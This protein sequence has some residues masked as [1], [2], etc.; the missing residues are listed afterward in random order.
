[1]R[2]NRIKFVLAFTAAFIIFIVSHASAA[3]DERLLG[4]WEHMDVEY[5]PVEIT[6]ITF[7]PGGTASIEDMY[8]TDYMDWEADGAVLHISGVNFLGVEEAAFAFKYR[9]EGRQ[10]YLALIDDEVEENDESEPK[11]II[12]TQKLIK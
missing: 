7:K 5:T 1:M 3:M 12:F 4:A 10:L 9:I 11:E 6:T 8:T 2:K